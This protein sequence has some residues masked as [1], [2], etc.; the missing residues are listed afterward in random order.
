MSILPASLFTKQAMK[1]ITIAS[2]VLAIALMWVALQYVF[3]KDTHSVSS[4]H[5]WEVIL[6]AF[7]SATSLSTPLFL[8]TV[9]ATHSYECEG[10]FKD[11]PRS[12]ARKLM[13][14][15]TFASV[16]VL[17]GNC[18]AWYHASDWLLTMQSIFGIVFGTYFTALTIGLKWYLAKHK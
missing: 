18:A 8:I 14:Q 4:F 5:M 3:Y 2:T 12:A 7:L 10:V 1:R 6:L 15:L 16:L 9:A 13:P 11:G 17:I